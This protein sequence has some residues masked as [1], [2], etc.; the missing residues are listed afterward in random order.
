M[1]RQI[2]ATMYSLLPLTPTPC[3]VT[4]P[5][6]LGAFFFPAHMLVSTNDFTV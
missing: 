1:P 3:G 5:D 2:D 4:A 6:V